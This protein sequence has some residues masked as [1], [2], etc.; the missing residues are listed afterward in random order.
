MIATAKT[1]GGIFTPLKLNQFEFQRRFLAWQKQEK[2]RLAL[3]AIYNIDA[4]RG[5][6]M[7]RNFGIDKVLDM[8]KASRADKKA[9]ADAEAERIADMMAMDAARQLKTEMCW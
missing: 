7:L 8:D 3:E 6:Y 4:K 5:A 2:K 9:R 1:P